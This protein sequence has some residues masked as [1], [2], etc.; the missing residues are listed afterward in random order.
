MTHQADVTGSGR[1]PLDT[2]HVKLANGETRALSLDELDAAFHEGWIDERTP[3][4]AAGAI[5][6]APLGEVAGLDG[7]PP[8]PSMP[9]SIAPLAFDTFGLDSNAGDDIPFDLDVPIDAESDADVLA[10][11]PRRG[12]KILGIMTAMI[13]VAGLGFVGFRATPA[14]QRAIASRDG[15]RSARVAAEAKPQAAPPPAPAPAA[16]PP[17]ATPEAIP[18]ILATALPN[19]P[20]STAKALEDKKAADEAEKKAAAEARKAKRPPQKRAK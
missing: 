13:V 10:F 16:A 11:R 18:T 4:L 3:V 8:P 17:P 14:L 15:G 6:W 7:T 1:H 20:A 12:R 9:N 2:W 19:A 5:R